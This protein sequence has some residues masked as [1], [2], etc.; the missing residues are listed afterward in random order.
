MCHLI[1]RNTSCNS[2]IWRG[3]TANKCSQNRSQASHAKDLRWDRKDRHRA[4]RSPLDCVEGWESNR[5]KFC[6]RL[7]LNLARRR[8]QVKIVKP[9]IISPDCTRIVHIIFR[10][11]TSFTFFG[12]FSI[13]VKIWLLLLNYHIKT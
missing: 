12:L 7:R 10:R 2:S 5:Q 6:V 11:E 3:H 9:N 8:F 1:F 13:F 4:Q